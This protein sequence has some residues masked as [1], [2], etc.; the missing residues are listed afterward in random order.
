MYQ[1]QTTSKDNSNITTNTGVPNNSVVNNENS[2]GAIVE[3][4]ILQKKGANKPTQN[5][6]YGTNRSESR[7]PVEENSS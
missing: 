1:S 3:K 2:E 7:P 6:S 5:G 4:Q